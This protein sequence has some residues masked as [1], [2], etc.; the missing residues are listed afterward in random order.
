MKMLLKACLAA[1]ALSLV[2]AVGIAGEI[3]VIVKT[4][5]SNFWQNVNKGAVAA[6]EPVGQQPR[7]LFYSVPSGSRPEFSIIFP[8][9]AQQ[10]IR[11]HGGARMLVE[12]RVDE[13]FH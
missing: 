7:R 2:P 6:I 8:I 13:D 10:E 3:A 5:N 12:G 11:V 4:T 9:R 1:T